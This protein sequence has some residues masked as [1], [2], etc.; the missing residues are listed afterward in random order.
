M[1]TIVAYHPEQFEIRLELE[2]ADKIDHAIAWLVRHRY[3][4]GKGFE[5]TPEGLPICPRHQI[6]MTKRE[7]QGD[8]WYS[9]NMGTKDDPSWCRGYASPS[10]PG[11][12]IGAPQQPPELPAQTTNGS[13]EQPQE[14]LDNDTLIDDINRE[15]FP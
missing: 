7:K 2:E 8:T 10:S 1:I 14:A 5:Y 12:N 6:P 9:H 11:W 15:L 3:R 4:P 13:P